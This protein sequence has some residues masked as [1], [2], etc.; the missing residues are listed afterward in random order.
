MLGI[1]HIASEPIGKFELLSIVKQVYG[2]NIQIEPDD[3]FVCDRS[4]NAGRFYRATGIVP[5][6]WQEMIEQMFNDNT[7]YTNFRSS[8]VYK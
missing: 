1:W 3:N 8:Y 7:P 4:L 2:L 6:P 5:P